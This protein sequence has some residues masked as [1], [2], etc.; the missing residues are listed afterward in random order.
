MRFIR[1]ADVGLEAAA[2]Q[3]ASVLRQGG[4]VLY[5]TDTLYGLGVDAQNIEAL[6]KL[7]TLKGRER[8]KPVS[9]IVPDHET[10]EHHAHLHDGAR[11]M[12]AKHL[13]GALTLVV[14]AKEHLPEALTL[15]G[16]VGLRIPD[17]TFT[18][19]LGYAFGAPYTA[20]SANLSGHQTQADP[21]DIVVS[22]GPRTSLIDLVIDDGVR[23][24]G[25]PSTVVLYTG[26]TPLVLRDGKITRE[27]LG[28]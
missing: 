18:L 13:P 22:F 15:N 28:L 12:A 24:G 2:L 10:L 9:L 21:T 11:A 7:R 4:I 16:A 23:D 20:T 17:D 1:I 25:I 14:P 8:K 6:E 26:D 19:A 27:A 3:A 5:P